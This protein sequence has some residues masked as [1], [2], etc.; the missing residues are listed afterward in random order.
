MEELKGEIK[1]R[2]EP[3]PKG[4]TSSLSGQEVGVHECNKKG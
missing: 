1:I 4:S 3:E 2:I